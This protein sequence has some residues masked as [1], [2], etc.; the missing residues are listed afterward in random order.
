MVIREIEHH[1]H[2]S[3]RNEEFGR[4][5]YPWPMR[6]RHRDHVSNSWVR[7]L[8]PQKLG[9]QKNSERCTGKLRCHIEDSVPEF[10]FAQPQERQRHR[11]VDV[12]TGLLSPGRVDDAIAVRPIDSPP[13]KRRRKSEEMACRTGDCGNPYNTPNTHADTMKAPSRPLPS[14]TQASEDVETPRR[15]VWASPTSRFEWASASA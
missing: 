12:C 15:P 1:R 2:Q 11:G 10:D 6:P 13:S 4:K 14:D 9:H 8:M 7:N 5:R 3:G